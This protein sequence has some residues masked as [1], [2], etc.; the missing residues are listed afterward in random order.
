MIDHRL[1]DYWAH[2]ARVKIIEDIPYQEKGQV[3]LLDGA[4]SVHLI[5]V[6]RGPGAKVIVTTPAPPPG[7]GFRWQRLGNTEYFDASLTGQVAKL[8]PT[9]DDD[10]RGL[11]SSDDE[12]AGR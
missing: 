6:L 11:S 3:A 1:G 2:L 9:T 4:S 5:D 10:S 8:H 7:E 12:E